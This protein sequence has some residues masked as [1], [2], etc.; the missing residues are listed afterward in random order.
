[1]DPKIELLDKDQDL[2]TDEERRLRFGQIDHKR[3]FGMKANTFLKEAGF[4][5]EMIKGEDY[6]KRILP[7]VGPAEYDMNILFRCVKRK[8]R[9]D[10]SH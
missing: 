9:G 8:S 7:V 2:K 3:V 4:E 6:D 10:G 1:M 5:I